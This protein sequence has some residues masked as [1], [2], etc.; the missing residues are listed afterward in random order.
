MGSEPWR[1][2][3][4]PGRRSLRQRRRSQRLPLVVLLALVA[5]AVAL[6]CLPMI[7]E[8]IATNFG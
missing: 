1:P 7:F 8:W 6:Y 3:G 5:S 2:D 4:R